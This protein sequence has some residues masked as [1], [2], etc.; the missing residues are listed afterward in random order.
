M[1]SNDSLALPQ[2]LRDVGEHTGNSGLI[3]DLAA[4]SS[5][6]LPVD[7][8]LGR[9]IPD[10]NSRGS[11][12]LAPLTPSGNRQVN[13]DNINE[14]VGRELE[15]SRPRRQSRSSRRQVRSPLRTRTSQ[16]L[17]RRD[18]ASSRAS[19]SSE[20][21]DPTQLQLNTSGNQSIN[22]EVRLTSSAVH[23]LMYRPVELD[24]AVQLA[25]SMQSLVD[26]PVDYGNGTDDEEEKQYN[27]VE[28]VFQRGQEQQVPQSSAEE[29]VT[30]IAPSL[31]REILP[32]IIPGARHFLDRPYVVS[33]PS[34]LT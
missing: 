28:N 1:T 6:R 17:A 5:Q 4:Q 19:T 34:T 30:I 2:A 11:R 8:M 23:D 7:V 26:D 9:S 22:Q 18:S 31:V 32:T 29:L 20:Q 21:L 10:S 14:A 16:R 33:L 12:Q 25:H 15:P 24:E 3:T 13:E 27:H